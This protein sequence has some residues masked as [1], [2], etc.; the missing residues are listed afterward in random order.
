MRLHAGM[1]RTLSAVHKSVLAQVVALR[2][3]AGLTLVQF[4]R[5]AGLSKQTFNGWQHGSSP[6]L[7]SLEAC[8]SVVRGRLCVRILTEEATVEPGGVNVR[9]DEAA[10][11]AALLDDLPDDA[12]QAVRAAA[13]DALET[14]YRRK[15][16]NPL[17]PAG[18]GSAP[19]GRK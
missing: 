10:E 5:R 3:R 16:A 2:A 9:T 18:D 17:A 13:Y 12:R 15:A 8:A 6:T 11:V 14:Y 19:S 4:M 7:E 1:P